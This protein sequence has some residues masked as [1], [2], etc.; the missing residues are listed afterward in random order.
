MKV[1][2]NTMALEAT[3]TFYFSISCHP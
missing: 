1:G 3:P 2:M